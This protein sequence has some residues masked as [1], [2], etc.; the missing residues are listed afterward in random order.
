[1]KIKK[2]FQYKIKT[3]FDKEKQKKGISLDFFKSLKQRAKLIKLND[4]NLN[5]ALQIFNK[6]NQFNFSLNRYTS[7]R[8]REIISSKNYRLML[9]SLKD[10]FGD[11]GIISS[12]ILRIEK[13]SLF[14]TDFAVSC[15]VISRYVED[16]MIYLIIKKIKILDISLN[17]KKQ[18]SIIT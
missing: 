5:R 2:F 16:Y 12:C 10:K 7:K 3:K 11:H 15:R 4:K 8:L 17:L 9:F 14:V 6:T 18:I 1:M 13:D